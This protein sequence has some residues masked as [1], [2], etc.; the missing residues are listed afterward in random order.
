MPASAWAQ[1]PAAEQLVITCSRAGGY[2]LEQLRAL[3]PTLPASLKGLTIPCCKQGAQPLQPT[4][5]LDPIIINNNRQ[6]RLFS[7][8][9]TSAPFASSLQRL[10]LLGISGIS[11]SVLRGILQP[12]PQLASLIVR[13]SFTTSRTSLPTLPALPSGLTSLGMLL[14]HESAAATL[15]V[16]SIA[17]CQNLCSLKLEAHSSSGA[18]HA[19]MLGDATK[20]SALTQLSYLD[21][22]GVQHRMNCQQVQQ[23]L[24]SLPQLSTAHMGGGAAVA[25]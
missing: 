6:Q 19:V 11:P 24:A 12:L 5:T 15:Q 9:I 21:L 25:R 23:L 3:L 22:S 8:S 7:S 18:Q 16:A 4:I 1:F 17:A 14:Q 13:I 10:D 20:L 2:N